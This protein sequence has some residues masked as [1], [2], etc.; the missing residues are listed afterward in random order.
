MKTKS[1]DYYER[2]KRFNLAL[3]K[4]TPD[5]CCF[6]DYRTMGTAGN[7]DQY[8]RLLYERSD[9]DVSGFQKIYERVYVDISYGTGNLIPLKMMSNFG[10]GIYTVTE[11]GVQIK[12]SHGRTM[13]EEE[14]PALIENPKEFIMEKILPRKY[15][16]L[17][18]PDRA[19]KS[20]YHAIFDFLSF[21]K[22]DQKTV[23]A[24][25]ID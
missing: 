9:A 16:I 19:V 11:A 14:Y 17:N 18:Q 24:I 23:Q 4:Q 7:G 25:E 15:P 10:E 12:G 13:E 6:P 8:Q 3:N 2:L 21:A 5:G 1:S 20:W 22:F